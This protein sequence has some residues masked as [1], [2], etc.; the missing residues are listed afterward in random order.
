[1]KRFDLTAGDVILL[2]TGGFHKGIHHTSLARDLASADAFAANVRQAHIHSRQA[3]N[4]VNGTILAIKVRDLELLEPDD[5]ATKNM[6]RYQIYHG[7]APSSDTG[8][9]P[10]KPNVIPR[11][12][13]ESPAHEPTPYPARPQQPDSFTTAPAAVPFQEAQQT[14]AQPNAAAL[15][16]DQ[17]KGDD[18]VTAQAKMKKRSN[19]KT[20]GLSL[21][22]GFAIGMVAVLI[23]W[24]IMLR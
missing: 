13:Q 12:P 20:F 1:M 16:N 7:A 5:L 18:P 19:W 23:V 3:D 21:L 2:T 14:P 4:T 17:I 10:N 11:A 8:Q 6:E 22:L 24:F 15:P 9:T